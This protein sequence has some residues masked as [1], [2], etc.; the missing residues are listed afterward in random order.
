MSALCGTFVGQPFQ[1]HSLRPDPSLV[2]S[3]HT[4][5]SEKWSVVF[6]QPIPKSRTKEIARSLIVMLYNSKN[7]N[8]Y[9]VIHGF[10]NGFAIWAMVG[11]TVAKA[12]ANP[13]KSTWFTTFFFLVRGNKSSLTLSD[14]CYFSTQP[15]THKHNKSSVSLLLIKAFN[16]YII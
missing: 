7:F 10:F 5:P 3:L 14:S 2:H 11:Y 12:C 6:P 16:D 9:L 13:R 1:Y 15:N 8:L 4:P